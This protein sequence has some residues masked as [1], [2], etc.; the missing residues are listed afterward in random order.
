MIKH[1]QLLVMVVFACTVA[2]AQWST[3]ST[4]NNQFAISTQDQLAP[5][6]ISDGTGGYIVS[7]TERIP[8]NFD[9]YAQRISPN[10][11]P[12]WGPNGVVICATPDHQILSGLVTDGDGGAIIVWED[13]TGTGNG[14][15][16]GHN[17]VFAQRITGSGVLAWAASGV[18]ISNAVDIQSYVNLVSDNAGGAIICW[19]DYRNNGYIGSDIYAQRVNGSGVT[20]WQLNGK[21]ICNTTNPQV[22]PRI[23][24][25]GLGGAFIAWEDYRLYTQSEIYFQRVDMNGS[26]LLTLQGLIACTAAN[27]QLFPEIISDGLGGAI[28]SWYDKRVN[29]NSGVGDLYAQRVTPTGTLSWGTGGTVLCNAPG[30]Q[31]ATFA[32]LTTMVVDGNGGLFCSWNDLRSGNHDIYVQRYSLAN[33]ASLWTPNGVV[34]NNNTFNE[35]YPSIALDGTGGVYITWDRYNLGSIDIFGQRYNNAGNAM[36]SVNGI[37]LANANNS[38]YNNQLVGNPDGTATLVFNDK[39][40]NINA[41]IYG[42]RIIS[43]GTCLP[44][45]VTITPTLTSVC[46]GGSTTLIAGGASTYVWANLGAGATK[47]VAPVANT[48]YTVTG[49]SSDGCSASV[50]TTIGVVTPPLLSV[51]ATLNTV[52][53]GKPTELTASGADTFLWSNGPTTASQIVNP[54]STTTYTVTGTNNN[55]CS[56]TLTKL[57]TVL[58]KPNITISPTVA[59][60][61]PG[62]SATLNAFGAISYVWNTAAVGSTQVL[63]P[64]TTTTYTVTG[65][66]S[67]GCT[68]TGTRTINVNST[69]NIVITPA[70]SSICMGGSITLTASGAST[71]NWGTLGNGSSKTVSPTATTTYTI[72]GTSSVGC[73]GSVT[74]TVTV[75]TNPTITITPTANTICSG[76]SV[77]LTAD[78]GATYTWSTNATTQTIISSPVVNTTYTVTGVSAQG[79]SATST[80]SI[81]VNQSPVLFISPGSATVCEGGTVQ[82]SASG[83]NTYIWSTNEITQQISVT[84]ATTTTYTVTGTATNGCTASSTRTVIINPLPLVNISPVNPAI[85]FGQFTQIAASGASS[86]VW[87]TNETSGTLNVSPPATTTYTVTGTSVNGCTATAT[88]TVVVNPLPNVTIATTASTI[89]SGGSAELT[90]SGA[91]GYTWNTNA[92]NATIVVSPIA[93]T[94][95][96]VTGI[97]PTGCIA[98]ATKTIVVNAN[99]NLILS[100]LVTSICEGNFATLGVSGAASYVWSNSSVGNT[101]SVNPTATTTYTVTGTAANGCTAEGTVLVNVNPLPVLLTTSSPSSV[102]PGASST[103][104]VSGAATY[105]WSSGST[106]S[107]EVVSPSTSSVYTVTG[108]DLLGCT[109]TATVGVTV[110]PLPLLTITAS[111]TAVCANDPV[112]L[113]ASGADNYMWSTT[114]LTPVITV[115][116]SSTTTYTVTGT[117]LN[118]GC[119]STETI[120]IVVNPCNAQLDVKVF[121]QGFYLGGGFMNAT[122]M[123]Q[124]V[125]M[126]PTVCDSI[127][128][129]LY[130]TTMPSVPLA[131]ETTLLKTDGTATVPVPIGLV[132]QS[133]YVVIKHR[134][135]LETWSALPITLSTVNNYDFSSSVS[136]AFGDNQAMMDTYAAIYSGDINQD[137]VV[138]AFDYLSLDIDLVLGLSGYLNTDLTGDGSTDAFDYLVIDPNVIAG[139]TTVI[140]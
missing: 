9:I 98:I 76:Q 140:P 60:I 10:G 78:G 24:Q 109:A 137:F 35:L 38:Q 86:F 3:N 99:P 13:S 41:N 103:L 14:G 66:G 105:S 29:G 68:N 45:V 43:T 31:F 33:G 12:L 17:D 39:R 124:G 128:V 102:C 88:K 116:P 15:I 133:C 20:L 110:L 52:C 32:N 72:T 117:Q 115:N 111:A 5:K 64:L 118:T 19:N 46:S 135:S 11:L 84:P 28:I 92:T 100:P 132:G 75:N 71:Y 104:T 8:G 93:T 25:D 30:D 23:C 51:T 113:T 6:V 61:C 63:S 16:R 74:K 62:G 37:P 48:T 94:T 139:L 26:T 96:T 21:P 80:V 123:N 55:G 138:D 49:T 107:S 83:A 57:I 126:D 97:E 73:T 130:S 127:T 58:P 122:L 101:I 121:L 95:Y 40:N 36:W 22:R 90:A 131:A 85:C 87:N 59:T 106:T 4:V 89:C 65:T 27:D 18:V 129:A 34:V 54:T 56:A 120:T 42:Q 77:S 82:L 67:N 44:P 125:S 1:L 81:D 119:S 7:W 53:S 50:T 79:C 70:V 136:A 69:P 134:N 112:V 91:T 2:H 114:E 47:V 108:T